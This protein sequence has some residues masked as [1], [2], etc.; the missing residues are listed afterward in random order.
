[1]A[2]SEHEVDLSGWARV[3]LKVSPKGHIYAVGGDRESGPSDS[4][5]AF[6]GLERLKGRI[7]RA[8]SLAIAL[9]DALCES[10][11]IAIHG[12]GTKQKDVRGKQFGAIVDIVTT[13][14]AQA[15]EYG[16]PEKEPQI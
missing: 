1:M 2:S 15:S 12:C 14:L 3:V 13:A 5:R 9:R 16:L 4:D 8:E 7:A 11:M 6:I 10:Q